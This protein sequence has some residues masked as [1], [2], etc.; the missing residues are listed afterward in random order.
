[1]NNNQ[2]F[3]IMFVIIRVVSYI[4]IIYMVYSLLSESTRF[5]CSWDNKYGILCPSCGATRATLSI[6]KGDILKALEYNTVYT[7][8]IF[9]SIILFILDDIICIVLRLFRVTKKSSLFEVLFEVDSG[10]NNV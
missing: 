2:V 5:V 3:R 9:P 1:V 7:T 8:A 10:D 4:L 6:I